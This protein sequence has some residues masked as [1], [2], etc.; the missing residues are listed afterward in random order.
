MGRTLTTTE[1]SIQVVESLKESGGATMGELSERLG[2]AKSTVH[3]HLSTLEANGY[4]VRRGN[5]YDLSFKFFH[6]GQHVMGQHE[7]VYRLA[8]ESVDALSTT[9]SEGVDFTVLEDG[10]LITICKD[11]ENPIDPVLRV[12]NY[13]HLHNSA[14]GKAVLAE[15]PDERVESVLEKWGL[16]RETENTITDR[17]TLFDQL[18]VIRDQGFAINDQEAYEGL[19]AAGVAV[20]RPD[21]TVL[22]GISTGGPAYRVSG[23]FL[24]REIPRALFEAKAEFEREL[25]AAVRST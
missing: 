25:E 15:L 11:V 17:E 14:A 7:Q 21:G 3:A 23:E 20:K 8:V 13:F 2:Y 18:A 4:V 24:H 6:F 5:E 1:T 10:R 9:V 19:R 16:P 12:G 22:G